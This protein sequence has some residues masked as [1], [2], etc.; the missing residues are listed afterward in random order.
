[1]L[2][3]GLTLL[4]LCGAIGL[5]FTNRRGD[6]GSPPPTPKSLDSAFAAFPVR[7]S[8]G[9]TALLEPDDHARGM[10]LFVFKSDCPACA[11][12]KPEWI[13]LAR[14]AREK[15]V[16]VV[17]LTLEELNPEVRGYFAGAV[18]TSRI[19]DPGAALASLQINV[20]PATILVTD[21]GRIA[22]HAAG[23]LDS[24]RTRAL[25]GML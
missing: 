16:D 12:Q 9:Q 15:A 19:A 17:A 23:V 14:L 21:R 5:Y 11:L 4:V 1:V 2:L 6:S 22:F 25:E 8:S 18:P 20:V 3:D 10:L 24:V 13:R 7:D